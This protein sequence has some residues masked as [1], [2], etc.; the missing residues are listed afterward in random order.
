MELNIRKNNKKVKTILKLY[1]VDY[2]LQEDRD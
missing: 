1:W 2:G